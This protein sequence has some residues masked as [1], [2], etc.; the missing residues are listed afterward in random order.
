MCA[1]FRVPGRLSEAITRSTSY[2]FAYACV[3]LCVCVR[4]C[5]CMFVCVCVCESARGARALAPYHALCLRPGLQGLVGAAA[6]PI[7]GALAGVSKVRTRGHARMT[8]RANCWRELGCYLFTCSWFWG[9]SCF[10][11]SEFL[12]QGKGRRLERAPRVR[13][14]VSIR[15]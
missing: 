13:V 6:S 5:V 11:C 9:A 4:M 1:H 7:G 3:V 12:S 14:Q 8:D 2:V 15:F 10:I